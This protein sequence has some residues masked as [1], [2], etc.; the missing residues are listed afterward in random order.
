[1]GL[2]L[3][4]YGGEAVGGGGSASLASSACLCFSVSAFWETRWVLGLGLWDGKQVVFLLGI[5]S[6]LEVG[7]L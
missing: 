2:L 6:G 1:L 5:Y 4:V 3:G 7:L